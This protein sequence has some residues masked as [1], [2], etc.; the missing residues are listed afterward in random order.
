[1]IFTLALAPEVLDRV[2]DQGTALGGVHAD[3]DDQAR[4]QGAIYDLGADEL[5]TP[6]P[7]V[8][9]NG[10]DGPLTVTPGDTVRL[11]VELEARELNGLEVDRWVLADT[12]TTVLGAQSSTRKT[13]REYLS[14]ICFRKLRYVS[15]LNLTFRTSRHQILLF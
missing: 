7:E 13:G 2:V 1:V 5:L 12:P 14:R 15:P 10:S 3:I 4:P 8:K 6:L 9:A 11:T